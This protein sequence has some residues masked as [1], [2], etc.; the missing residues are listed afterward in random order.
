LGAPDDLASGLDLALF[1]A[2]ACGLL[3][4]SAD[5]TILLVNRQF[6]AWLGYPRERLADRRLQDLLTVGGKI[7][8]HTHLAPLLQMQGSVSEL[9]LD[10]L[11]A[12]GSSVPM[13]LNAARRT[14]RGQIFHD[15]AT[16]VARDRDTYEKELLRSRKRLESMV[17]TATRLEAEARDHAQAAE[18]M[19][20]I[21]SHDLRNPL[22][23]IA[24]GLSLLSGQNLPETHQR[25]LQR[26]AR[27]AERANGLIADLLDF[28][29][30]R[31]GSG[32]AVDLQPCDL[33]R[34]IAQAVEEIGALYVG[35]ELVHVHR[36]EQ[37]CLADA[38]R[39][40]Q[41]LG[42]LISNAMAYGLPDEPVCV[43][44]V[45]E[46]G[47]CSVAVHNQG[48]PIPPA[49][50]ARIFEPMSRGTDSPGNA[51]SVGLGLFIV[52]GIVAA[53]GGEI[54]LVSN[55]A[56]TTFTAKFPRR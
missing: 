23:S 53:H 17:A 44:S 48:P 31:L 7:F 11:R 4:T 33:E 45:I 39:L 29:Q 24:L 9:K 27:A 22:A 12:D 55:E 56:G 54:S 40:A 49:L 38:N 51:R 8:H 26:I 46:D 14:D 19:I 10:F 21:V 41:L 52:R 42:N 20:G 32:L 2:A 36:G 37:T 5:G 34:V 30:A 50:Q 28:T 25:T 16:Y 43:V 6:C 1:D 15:V 13:V 35:R 18:Q 3:R 47:Q